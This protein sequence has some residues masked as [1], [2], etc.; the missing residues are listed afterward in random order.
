M[1]ATEIQSAIEAV[2]FAAK[3]P[4]E[5]K[6]LAA[7]FNILESEAEGILKAIEDS[8]STSLDPISFEFTSESFTPPEVTM[9][10]E[11]GLVADM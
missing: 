10:S 6:D 9:A 11:S 2:V 8:P 7:A 3:S 4:V 1:N 5:V